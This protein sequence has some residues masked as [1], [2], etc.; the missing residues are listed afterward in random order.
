MLNVECVLFLGKDDRMV[1]KFNN[2][3]SVF[4]VCFVLAYGRLKFFKDVELFGADFMY[5]DTDFMFFVSRIGRKFVGYEFK[6]GRYLG[7]F[8]IVFDG[9]FVK[10]LKFVGFVLKNYAYIIDDGKCV[11]KV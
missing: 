5:M 10:G 6:V 3:G 2:K 7:E 8:I 1:V 4:Y 11:C 9:G